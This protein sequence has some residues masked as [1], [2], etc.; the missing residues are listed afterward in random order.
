MRT[1]EIDRRG[2][3]PHPGPQ[4]QRDYLDALDI[5]VP[6]FATA[7]GMEPSRLWAM[8]AGRMSLDVDAALRISRALQLPAERL[9][10]LQVRYDFAAARR[11]ASLDA[12]GL[13]SDSNPRPFPETS[14]RGRLGRSIDASGEASFFFQEELVRKVTGDRYAGLHAL[15]LGDR[16]RIYDDGG[17]AIW[18]GPVLQNLDGRMLLPFVRATEW[19][20]WFAA[21][22]R[23][24][25][26]FGEDHA[27]FFARMEAGQGV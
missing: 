6:T 11:D 21:G 13:L 23:A 8:L 24:D 25:L 1:T 20:A 15:W 17:N 7:V 14:L 3:A 27:A 12:V 4:I 16:L 5:D 18:S 2:A 26:A 22:N 9:M 19:S 10:Q